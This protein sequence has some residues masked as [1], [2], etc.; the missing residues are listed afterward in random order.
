MQSEISLALFALC[1]LFSSLQSDKIFIF[2]LI[3]SINSFE[4]HLIFVTEFPFKMPLHS[5]LVTAIC[6]LR[7]GYALLQFSLIVTPL[8]ACIRR[9]QWVN[10]RQSLYSVQLSRPCFRVDK[11]P[12]QSSFLLLDQWH[13]NILNIFKNTQQSDIPSNWPWKI[14]LCVTS[15]M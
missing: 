2:K 8:I 11:T 5:D 13:L 4:L 12:V 6:E 14:L 9:H 15:C 7:K 3:A 1:S 10:S